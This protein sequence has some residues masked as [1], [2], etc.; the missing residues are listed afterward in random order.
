MKK[1]LVIYLFPLLSL[2]C[3]ITWLFAIDRVNEI[4]PE[5]GEDK[6]EGFSE[7][8]RLI[9][10]TPDGVLNEYELNYQLKEFN[11]A[12]RKRKGFQKSAKADLEWVERGPGNVSGR[13][14][15]LIVDPDD[16]THQ[17]WF[18]GSVSGGIW[19]TT[20]GG[21]TW[22]ELTADIPILSTS[23]MA[24]AAS[25]TN[26]IYAGT[27]EGFGGYGMVV[28]NG[29]YKST[30]KG[31]AGTWEA[32][33]ST[34]FNKDFEYVNRVIVDYNSEDTVLACTNTGIFKSVDGGGSWYKVYQLPGRKVQ[35]LVADPNNFNI[36]YAGVNRWGII[37]SIDKGET[38]YDVNNG[39]GEAKRFELAVSPVNP[40]K[41]FASVEG[42]GAQTIVY[43]SFDKG[44]TWRR[45]LEKDG[46]S[47]N[48]LR[49]QGWFDNVVACHPFDEDIVYIAGVY[50]GKLEMSPVTEESEP[51]V[52]RVDTFGIGDMIDF[53]SFG[54][55]HFNGAM[56]LGSDE[57]GEDIEEEDWRSVEIRI[58][59]AYSQKAHRF[60]VPKGSGAGVPPEKYN[61]ADYVDVP[62]EVW[63][64]DNNQQ[65][66]VSFRD[67]ERDGGFNLIEYDTDLPSKGR[68]YLF[69]HGLPYNAS[70]PDENIAQEVGY[71]YKLL[72]FF[73]PSILPDSVWLPDEMDGRVVVKYGRYIFQKG[74][75]TT[76]ADDKK[77]KN[78]HVDHHQ[79]VP[80]ITNNAEKRFTLLN[81]NDGGL[82]ISIDEGNTWKQ[83]TDGY[84][85]T[86]FYGV[87]KKKG[88]NEYIGGMQDNGTW[89]SKKGEKAVKNTQY[90][91]KL[92]GDGFE[93]LW[94]PDFPQRIIGSTYNNYFSVTN[95]GGEDWE[96]AYD[97]ING[98]GPF[99]S[100][101][102]NSVE[103]PNVIFAVGGRGVYRHF[104]FALGRQD[105]QLIPVGDMFSVERSAFTHDVEVSMANKNIVWAGT[106]MY[107]NPDLR[108][109]VSPNG[110]DSFEP[111]SLYNDTRI[112]FS[113]SIE[114]HPV[115]DSCAF[116]LF[117]VNEKPKILR[118]NNLGKSWNDISGF[119]ENDSSSNGFPDVV[120]YS[121]LVHPYDT[122]I[123]WAGTEI[124][125]FETVNSGGDWYYADNGLPAVSIFQLKIMDNQI[126][127]GT[128]GRGI[129]SLDLATVGVKEVEGSESDP[130]IKIYPN[131]A[132]D[133]VNIEFLQ[134]PVQNFD[135]KIIDAMGKIVYGGKIKDKTSQVNL[136]YLASGNYFIVVQNG[137]KIY[138]RQFLKK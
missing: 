39:I 77:N 120:V 97:G 30:A 85:T 86:Q 121:L 116:V 21:N 104:N 7:Y 23:T 65:L 134:S 96:Y 101:L 94:H 71:T 138:R 28:G 68:E 34:Q 119:G 106:G 41:V 55:R 14:R 36:M 46:N 88:H 58:G 25:N 112:G 11:K 98:D 64:T 72:Y 37:K 17:T 59:S 89:Q 110:G 10:G 100:R 47:F 4:E 44:E 35:D 29:I 67:N 18:A 19:K 83:I 63:D 60:V 48:W 62:F 127:V 132:T 70:Q 51:L 54:G 131:P 124:G 2:L 33:P 3:I 6:P 135:I 111:T 12:I 76:L 103:N 118:T 20:D 15:A 49:S 109:Y 90:F 133:F 123:I 75:A 105:W 31:A 137:E 5:F 52:L 66:M 108:I 69:V 40:E 87:A 81:S 99:V 80:V 128:H 82:G 24:M 74:S 56:A 125:L 92:E 113:T 45:F 27:G 129:W 61:Y 78:L 57:D 73:W 115:L 16:P 95:N 79:I 9:K 38:W 26:V 22:E 93:V 1:K 50:L 114:S 13:T 117:S 107:K 126:I 130:D 43:Y 42:Y 122:S 102:S 84:N 32:I 8:N 53:I 136:G 91:D